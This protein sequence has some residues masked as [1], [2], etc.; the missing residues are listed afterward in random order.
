MTEKEAGKK[1]DVLLVED[2]EDHIFLASRALH[3]SG[4]PLNLYVVRDGEEALEF[5]YQTGAHREAPRPDLILLDIKLPGRDGFEVLQE[6]KTNESFK[7][8]PIVM[9][10]SS[11]A[12]TDVSR[13]YVLGANS[14][15][16]KPV[17]ISELVAK[18]RQIPGYWT[19]LNVL[20]PDIRQK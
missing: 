13:A 1:V 7:A 12:D 20:P 9:L 8:I 2:N 18:L 14:Y 3:N 17:D 19:Q 16:T 15:I 10:T 5:I 4:L 6:L 11:G